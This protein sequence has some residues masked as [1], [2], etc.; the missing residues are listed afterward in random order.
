MAPPRKRQ[1]ARANRVANATQANLRR[2]APLPAKIPALRNVAAALLSLDR[3]GR[4][5]QA[6][7]GAEN[8][9][10]GSPR[11]LS[12]VPVARLIP[13]I[14]LPRLAGSLRRAK[15]D[16]RASRARDV[17]QQGAAGRGEKPEP[18]VE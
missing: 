14:D 1:P 7:A 9:F 6:S 11:N 8:L 13:D 12:G 5:T 10:N 4:V 16:G 17:N 18:A 2:A 3:G 15:R